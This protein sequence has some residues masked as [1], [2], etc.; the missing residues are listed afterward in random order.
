MN[1]LEAC[2]IDTP[3]GDVGECS[4]FTIDD[5]LTPFTLHN[6][7]SN[8]SQ[9][10]FSLWVKTE[11]EEPEVVAEPADDEESGEEIDTGMSLLIRGAN[12]SVTN[13]WVYHSHSFPT[14]GSDL[15]IYF[16]KAGTYYI[17]HP[18]LERGM[19]ATDW[20]ESPLDTEQKITDAT[21]TANAAK[22]GVDELYIKLDE[23]IQMVVQ[24]INNG[25][26]LEQTENGW[27]F[28]GGGTTDQLIDLSNKLANL[29]TKTSDSINQLKQ[30]IAANDKLASYV[31]I[32]ESGPEPVIK[33][34]T[35]ITNA[36]TG[37]SAFGKFSL[38][39]TPTAIEFWQEGLADPIAY[40][41]NQQLYI[42]KAVIKQELAVGGFVLKQHGNRNNVGFLWKGVTS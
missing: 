37:E 40:I 39:I 42:E 2:T 22:A 14:Y 4:K 25:T 20:A 24:A 26:L 29:D 16:T 36:E 21:N 38:Q 23:S 8:G 11:T 9:Y 10:T 1:I 28:A 6:V 41:S 3:F 19:V 35:Y 12:V 27:V 32:D 34:G 5:V 17:Y 15:K 31:K 33:M 18:Q 30:D 13:R 7:M